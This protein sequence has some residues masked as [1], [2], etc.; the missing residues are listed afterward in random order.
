MARP[1][2]PSDLIDKLLVRFPEGMRDK[3]KAEA[4]KN[5]RS[6]NA[7]IID[8]LE[9]SFSSPKAADE[10]FRLPPATEK[11][12]IYLVLDRDGLP[13][14]WDE[15]RAHIHGIL[16]PVSRNVINMRTYIVNPNMM[17]SSVRQDEAMKVAREYEKARKKVPE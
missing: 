15:I 12:T 1:A 11:N 13:S 7:E 16:G 2:Y 5:K 6:M 4:E 3:I 14:S 8:R 10:D 17:S 9:R